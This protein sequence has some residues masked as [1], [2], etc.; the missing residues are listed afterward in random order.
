[1]V[2]IEQ[3][4]TSIKFLLKSPFLLFFFAMF[5]IQWAFGPKGIIDVN[6]VSTIVFIEQ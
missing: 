3:I 1:M 2:F 4:E 5:C 6:A